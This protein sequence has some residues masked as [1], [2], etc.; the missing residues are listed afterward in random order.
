MGTM[1]AVHNM[2]SMCV[3]LAKGPSCNQTNGLPD[4]GKTFNWSASVK[5]TQNARM[6]TRRPKG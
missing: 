5:K 4:G 6:R 3:Y 2:H 1:S